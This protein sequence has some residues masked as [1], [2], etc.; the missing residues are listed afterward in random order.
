MV[1]GR[2]IRLTGWE[3]YAAGPPLGIWLAAVGLVGAAAAAARYG[4]RGQ[5]ALAA[6][7]L[8]VAVGAWLAGWIGILL[9][10]RPSSLVIGIAAPTPRQQRSW[11]WRP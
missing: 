2:H 3:W 10:G 11:C 9:F 5:R 1:D 8:P 4:G 6:G 7:L